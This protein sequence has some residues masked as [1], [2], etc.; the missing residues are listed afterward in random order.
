[1]NKKL[2]NPTKKERNIDKHLRIAKATKG[3]ER[4]VHINKAEKLKVKYSFI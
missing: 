3:H 2:Y 4:E 1:M